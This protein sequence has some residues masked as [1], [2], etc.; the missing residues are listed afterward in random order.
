MNFI[1]SLSLSLHKRNACDAILIIMNKYIKM[2]RYI[3][4]FIKIK[5]V[6]LTDLLYEEIYLKYD[7]S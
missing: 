6:K 4:T 3:F 7:A 2:T 1:V 5:V